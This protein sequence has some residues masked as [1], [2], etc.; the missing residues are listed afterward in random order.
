MYQINK[1]KLCRAE[2]IQFKDMLKLEYIFCIT[3]KLITVRRQP[4]QEHV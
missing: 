2:L 1:D 4:K 3:N